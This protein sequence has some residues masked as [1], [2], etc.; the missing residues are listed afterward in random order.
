[1]YLPEKGKIANADELQH[2]PQSSGKMIY[3]NYFELFVFRIL[4]A[5][6][7]AFYTNFTSQ[8][9]GKREVETF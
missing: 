5:F 4:A 8:F 7:A 9:N 3:A 2:T 1:V 6:I